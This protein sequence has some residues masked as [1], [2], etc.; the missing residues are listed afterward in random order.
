[1]VFHMDQI[2]LDWIDN[3]IFIE[4]PTRSGSSPAKVVIVSY[5]KVPSDSWVQVN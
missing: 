4:Q 1:M 3:L 5:K 2:T